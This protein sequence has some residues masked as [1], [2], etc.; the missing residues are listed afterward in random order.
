MKIFLLRVAKVK[1][2]LR[3]R[4]AR[5]QSTFLSRP[6]LRRSLHRPPHPP[7]PPSPRAS[8]AH[9]NHVL[10]IALAVQVFFVLVFL[11]VGLPV[12]VLLRSRHLARRP[13]RPRRRL[14][15]VALERSRGRDRLSLPR[16]RVYARVASR[17]T[18]RGAV[19]PRASW[20][21]VLGLGRFVVDDSPWAMTR[22]V[23]IHSSR[24][25]TRHH[26]LGVSV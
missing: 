9:R 2:Y 16:A 24:P 22:W 25:R 18:L 26:A 13:P 21:V 15:H 1:V 8:L 10:I 12:V 6:R 23:D 20:A 11:V 19:C 14:P 5:G 17:V 4:R 3:E 7:S